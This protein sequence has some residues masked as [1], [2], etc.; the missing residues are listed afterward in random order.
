MDAVLL[1][2][3]SVGAKQVS[4]DGKRL[5]E[6]PKALERVQSLQSL[7]M[8][9]NSISALPRHLS[10]LTSVSRPWLAHWGC[11]RPATPTVSRSLVAHFSKRWMQPADA[12]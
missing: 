4:L 8:K 11:C 1:K 2:A 3:A 12:A 10:N 9:N 5:Q 7:T 6:V